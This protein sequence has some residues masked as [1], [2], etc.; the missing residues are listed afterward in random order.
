MYKPFFPLVSVLSYEFL[1]FLCIWYCQKYP[2]QVDL[3]SILTNYCSYIT[4][5]SLY[6]ISSPGSSLSSPF[7]FVPV[8]NRFF[9]RR[10]S[11]LRVSLCHSIRRR[12]TNIF[13]YAIECFGIDETMQSIYIYIYIYNNRYHTTRI[14]PCGI[15]K[16]STIGLPILSM[17]SCAQRTSICDCSLM[18][19]IL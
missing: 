2:L 12:R 9:H 19:H 17:T 6:L 14:S 10:R 16:F 15:L 1:S 4:S 11:L 7:S 8:K 18:Y 5:T 13:I 3:I